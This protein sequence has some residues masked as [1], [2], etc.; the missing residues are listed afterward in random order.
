MLVHEL[1][2]AVLSYTGSTARS[3]FARE[4]YKLVRRR[5]GPLIL[6][7][8][9]VEELATLVQYEAARLGH[10]VGW[11]VLMPQ[12]SW[13]EQLRER[14]APPT[15]PVVRRAPTEGITTASDWGQKD[16]RARAQ[17][18][19]ASPPA[20]GSGPDDV[21][22]KLVCQTCGRSFERV[23]TRG[24]KPLQCP[25]CRQVSVDVNW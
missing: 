12:P 5:T 9:S 20:A 22:E 14:E 15:E 21:M 4:L 2:F 1:A 24:R 23:R 17:R 7:I 19:L 10:T 11:H 6:D 18:P 25:D 3:E 8:L 13:L 16:R